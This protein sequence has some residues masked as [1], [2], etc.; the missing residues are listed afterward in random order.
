MIGLIVFI[1]S[2][3]FA[4]WFL[5]FKKKIGK[6]L[7]R[8][9]TA[10]GRKL[11]LLER[12]YTAY[13]VIEQTK[14]IAYSARLQGKVPQKGQILS[15]IKEISTVHQGL[16]AS[17]VPA[18]GNKEET[19]FRWL[20]DVDYES[21][22]HFHTRQSEEDYKQITQQELN[23]SFDLHSNKPLWRVILIAQND[24]EIEDFEIVVV[25]HHL[26]CDGISG[27]ILTVEF[28]EILNHFVSGGK[29]KPQLDYDTSFPMEE[30]L[31]IRPNVFHI[32]SV[33]FTT[34]ILSKYKKPRLGF[35]PVKQDSPLG[36]ST[37]HIVFHSIQ[38]DKLQQIVAV[39]KRE[40]VSV[41]AFLSVC[42]TAAL[43][44]FEMNYSNN[45]KVRELSNLASRKLIVSR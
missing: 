39:S 4:V 5:I 32:V 16:K 27:Q 19:E 6:K 33:L 1:S 15:A 3:A 37:D 28:L 11:G 42:F 34:Y 7:T 21:V 24:R 10:G 26:I 30:V 41:H 9:V 40:R 25:V 43:A 13:H 44:K 45:Q 20:D 17:L 38:P 29:S 12:Y 8:E 31:D 23:S 36:K 22:Y 18:A 14:V 35:M 2:I